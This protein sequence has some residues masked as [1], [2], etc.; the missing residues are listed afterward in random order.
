VTR[1]TLLL[2]L[3]SC[4]AVPSGPA[5]E[6]TEEPER[7]SPPVEG[8]R[9]RVRVDEAL[10]RM[11]IRVCFDGRPPEVLVPM[12]SSA[13]RVLVG[14]QGDRGQP[15]RHE[16]TGRIELGRLGRGACVRY[17][18]DLARAGGR[19]AVR[20]G[21]DLLVAQALFLWRPPRWA[22]SVRIAIEIE[23]PPGVHVSSAWPRPTGS[24]GRVLF[25]P[26]RSVWKAPGNVVFIH[27]PPLHVEVGSTQLEIAILE[28]ELAVARADVERWL[29]GALRA[30]S[31][32][33]GRFHRPQVHV[34]VVP[35]GP[36]SRPVAF[37]LVRRGGGPSVMLLVHENAGAEA[38]A[39]DWT[40]VHELSHL[41]LPRMHREDRWIAEGFATYYQEVL[42]ARAGLITPQEAWA[43]LAAG[44][45]RGRFRG[46]R[47]TLWRD[48]ER[49]ADV[50]RIYWAGAAFVLDADVRFRQRGSSLDRWIGRFR[51]SWQGSTDAWRGL[52]VLG[53]IDRLFGQPLARPLAI[54]YGRMR[55]YPD[56]DTLLRR[57]GVRSL[58][59]RRVQF[60]DEAPLAAVRRAIT[61]P[62]DAVVNAE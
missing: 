10:R 40:A 15:L 30:A 39:A 5:G 54:R 32:M 43:S 19:Q 49:M 52:E 57:L 21:S 17:E 14:A 56:T 62:R 16:P 2:T 6:R 47:P 18:V 9:Y 7:L 42:R 31:A 34:A 59:D 38:L 48:A 33:D 36:G 12:S 61:A 27:A 13:A 28:G 25:R 37:G 35:V 11:G 26:D 23:G 50:G 58:G 1:A 22:P 41:A 53:R 60:D 3:A 20:R 46:R 44:F 55:T 29:T 24:Q 51:P 4:A 8:V 45:E